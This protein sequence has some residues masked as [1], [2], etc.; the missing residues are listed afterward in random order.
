[1]TRALLLLLP[2]GALLYAVALLLRCRHRHELAARLA[3]GGMGLRCGSCGRLR[4]HPW[5]AAYV[6]RQAAQPTGI[7]REGRAAA[8]AEEVTARERWER[9]R[10]RAGRR[11]AR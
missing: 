10:D 5:A 9:G 11:E 2:V 3:D 8:R 4:A 1:M 6:P 7:E